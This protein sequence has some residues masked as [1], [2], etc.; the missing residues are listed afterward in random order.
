MS[1]MFWNALGV[2]VSIM[3]GTTIP[4]TDI[5]VW[6]NI[7]ITCSHVDLELAVK[8]LTELMEEGCNLQTT[9]IHVDSGNMF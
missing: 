7:L 9:G 1:F 4:V 8:R 3:T 2:R 5:I 6:W